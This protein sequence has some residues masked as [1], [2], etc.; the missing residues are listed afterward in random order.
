MLSPPASRFYF[1][2]N[3]CGCLV[4]TE[5]IRIVLLCTACCC[6]IR[7]TTFTLPHIVLQPKHYSHTNVTTFVR[8]NKIAP[9]FV[10]V[11]RNLQFIF[12]HH[13][14]RRRRCRVR[15]VVC[16]STSSA[17]RR[18]YRT[19]F[20]SCWTTF[21]DSYGIRYSLMYVSY[22]FCAGFAHKCAPNIRHAMRVHSN[23]HTSSATKPIYLT[24][25]WVLCAMCDCSSDAHVCVEM[26][27]IQTDLHT[28]AYW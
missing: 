23:T 8:Q 22:G 6:P 26:N 2:A 28:R 10:S 20:L 19:S 14:C 3:C 18:I 24:D 1:D 5:N 11:G 17:C 9:S 15:F 16:V 21:K 4:F 7:K 12:R 25:L 27:I 13:L